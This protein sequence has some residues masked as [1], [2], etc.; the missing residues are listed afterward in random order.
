MDEVL[1]VQF[2]AGGSRFVSASADGT[3]CLYHTATGETLSILKGHQGEVSKV[4]FNMKGRLG[5]ITRVEFTIYFLQ[6]CYTEFLL[7][8]GGGGK[9]C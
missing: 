2:D 6:L 3:A 9:K 5:D 7:R 8:G 4:A 1:D